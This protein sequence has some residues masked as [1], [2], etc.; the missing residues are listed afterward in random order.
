MYIYLAV[1]LMVKVIERN[2]SFRQQMS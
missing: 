1:Y 2:F